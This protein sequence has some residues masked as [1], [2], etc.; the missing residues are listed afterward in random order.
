MSQDF[1][2]FFSALGNLPR[3]VSGEPCKQKPIG[4]GSKEIGEEEVESRI[5]NIF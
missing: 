2:K 4:K 5:M 1:Y 3:K